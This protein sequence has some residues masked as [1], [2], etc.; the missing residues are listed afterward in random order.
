[1]VHLYGTC[2]EILYTLNWLIN[3]TCFLELLFQVT[4]DIESMSLNDTWRYMEPCECV[5]K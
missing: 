3:V 1:M 2:K 4:I 5:H